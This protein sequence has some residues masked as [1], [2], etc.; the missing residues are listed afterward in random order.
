MRFGSGNKQT[1][2]DFGKEPQ[3]IN[4]IRLLSIR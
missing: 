1:F 3:E 2:S 4:V